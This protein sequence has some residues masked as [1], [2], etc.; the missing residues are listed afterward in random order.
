MQQQPRTSAESLMF[1]YAPVVRASLYA[2]LC[3]GWCLL[4]MWQCCAPA[5][6]ALGIDCCTHGIRSGAQTW[7]SAG[8]CPCMPGFTCPCS[9]CC[10]PSICSA[11]QPGVLLLPKSSMHMHHDQTVRHLCQPGSVVLVDSTYSHAQMAY[12]ISSRCCLV[13]EIDS[14]C[15]VCN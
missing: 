1:A 15:I 7:G 12:A 13:V 3:L 2:M 8:Q 5:A 10:T 6:T 14:P 9:N 11:A 4:V